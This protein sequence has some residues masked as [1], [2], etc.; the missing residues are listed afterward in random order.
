V[1]CAEGETIG[2]SETILTILI[3]APP[4]IFA[5]TCHE[6]AHGWVASRY[7][8]PTALMRG[9][10]TL[11]PLPHVDPVG[12]IV[13]PLVLAIM[14]APIIG[15][16]KPVPVNFGNLKNPK[17]HMGLVAA[18]G[19]VT[20]LLLA[21]A[22]GLLLNVVLLAFPVS[23]TPATAP[24]GGGAGGFFAPL[25]AMLIWGI[26]INVMLA[27]FNL[28]PIPPMDGS[29]VAISLLPMPYA[30]SFAKLERY[31]F[32]PLLILFFIPATRHAMAAVVVPIADLLTRLFLHLPSLI[33]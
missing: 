9:R 10:L 1:P 15:W 3:V 16:A 8:D 7:G 11:N 13:V 24:G 12:T 23:V 21:A 2:V 31:G 18:A 4:A 6:V 20:N 28:L 29:K 22:C 14:H 33:L 19:P 25:I 27:L 26:Q 32:L 5:I 17:K 30:R